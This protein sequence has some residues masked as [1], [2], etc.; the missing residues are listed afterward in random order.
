MRRADELTVGEKVYQKAD[1]YMFRQSGYYEIVK[2]EADTLNPGR[3]K[4]GYTPTKDGNR[5]ETTYPHLM[6]RIANSEVTS[7]IMRDV[8]AKYAGATLIED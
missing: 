2:S 7:Q 6:Y 1:G 8:A 4:L 5:G 3:W